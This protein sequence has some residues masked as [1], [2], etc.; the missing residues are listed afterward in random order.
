VPHM[1]FDGTLPIWKQ[2]TEAAV[3]AIGEAFE[4]GTR[5]V[6]AGHAGAGQLFGH[7]SNGIREH[8]LSVAAY[9]LVDA[10]VPTGGVSRLEQLE[11][12]DHPFAPELREIWASGKLF[13]TDYWTD[14]SFK[15]LVPDDAKL[16]KLIE[17][18]QQLP[19]DYWTEQIPA[20]P[21]W[22]DAPVAALLFIENAYK[23]T[24]ALARENGWPLLEL[25]NGNHW[26]MLVQPETAASWIE[27][28]IEA[29][30]APRVEW[31]GHL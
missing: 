26:S 15:L 27:T 1:R 20:T 13:P 5:V 11:A 23:A 19:D 7:I 28:L 4:A 25:A 9:V 17:E 10:G 30:L 6:F 22:P 12:N 29:S 2:I 18:M 8:G 3:A 24:S 21:S 16:E 31:A 14:P